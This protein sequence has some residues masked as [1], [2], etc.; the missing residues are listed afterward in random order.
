MVRYCIEPPSYLCEK[1]LKRIHREERIFAV[2][3]IVIFSAVLVVVVI[4]VNVSTP[5][6]EKTQLA[7][8]S[9]QADTKEEAVVNQQIPDDLFAPYQRSVVKYA[10]YYK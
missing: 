4:S 5:Y 9:P 10:N 6:S 8:Q 2:K 3:R 1:I 7:E